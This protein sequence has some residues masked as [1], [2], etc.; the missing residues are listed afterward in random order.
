VVTGESG[1]E[2]VH[3]YEN[4]PGY[5]EPT[6]NEMELWAAVMALTIARAPNFP[7]DLMRLRKIVIRTDSL[8]LQENF[9]NALYNWRQNKW[10]KRDGSP[11]ENAE[12]WDKLLDEWFRALLPVRFEW[13]KGKK[14]VHTKAVDTLAKK[15][16]DHALHPP[17]TTRKA[18]R[19]TSTKPLEQ[20]SVPMRGQELDILVV[21][22]K[23]NGMA[24][25]H[26]Y[27]YQVLSEGPDF[28]KVDV[29][30]TSEPRPGPLPTE[31]RR[32]PSR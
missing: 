29:A 1:E 30:H 17:L 25:H 2:E 9:N 18:R 28:H 20:G 4:L 31:P 11:V 16:A 6:N 10:L 19:K 12:L 21:N 14:G 15:S 32:R 26:R 3:D 7:V 22:E 23:W 27:T 24:R 5:R 8:Y 13:I